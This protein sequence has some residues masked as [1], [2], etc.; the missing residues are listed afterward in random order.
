MLCK[1]NTKQKKK[2]TLEFK[3]RNLND[4]KILQIK[5]VLNVCDWQ[6]LYNGSIDKVLNVYQKNLSEAID[7]VAPEKVF[8]I[9][10]KQ[11]IRE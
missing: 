11:R 3:A 7:K 1:I 4:S 6:Q 5:Q 10:V 9:S 8:R 2:D